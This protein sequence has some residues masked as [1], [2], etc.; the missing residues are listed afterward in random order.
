MPWLQWQVSEGV[1]MKLW[2]LLWLRKGLR[3]TRN[4]RRNRIPRGSWKIPKILLFL[5]RNRDIIWSLKLSIVYYPRL[6]FSIKCFCYVMNLAFYLLPVC[7]KILEIILFNNLYTY[8]HT[9]NP[10]TKNQSGFSPGDFTT[11]QLLYLLDE[12]NQAF[13]STKSF[14]VRTVFLDISRDFDKVWHDGLNFWLEQNDISGKLL[15]LF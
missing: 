6:R 14:E 1:S 10:I 3:L 11:N 15:R 2:R 12:I 5:G 9:N 13:D 7:G 8:L 4:W